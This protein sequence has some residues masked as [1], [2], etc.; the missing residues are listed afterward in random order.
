M[1]HFSLTYV[2]KMLHSM[3]GA[4]AIQ[5]E[6]GGKNGNAD[7]SI[8]LGLQDGEICCAR[9]EYVKGKCC[10][11]TFN[12][13]PISFDKYKRGLYDQ[14]VVFLLRFYYLTFRELLF[15]PLFIFR[16]QLFFYFRI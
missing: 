13:K 1:K 8:A 15:F 10:L 6:W 9:F 3:S 5:N 4:K 2:S 16:I 11:T 14:N 7:F 12:F